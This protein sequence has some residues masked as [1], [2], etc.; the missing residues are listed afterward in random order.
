MK[1]QQK[2]IG[3]LKKQKTELEERLSQQT[4]SRSKHVCHFVFLFYEII[5]YY[6]GVFARN[7]CDV[8]SVNH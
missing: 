6:Q 8:T 5:Q 3:D 2:E 1:K 7:Y 4:T